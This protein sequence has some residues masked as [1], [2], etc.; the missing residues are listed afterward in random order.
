MNFRLN[1][2]STLS[3]MS[4]YDKIDDTIDEY[5]IIAIHPNDMHWFRL[6]E[7]F[8]W[9]IPDDDDDPTFNMLIMAWKLQKL[10]KIFGIDS[11]ILQLGDKTVINFA[12]IMDGHLYW[13]TDWKGRN[14]RIWSQSNCDKEHMSAFL[15]KLWDG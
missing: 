6:S 5:G 7:V 11:D 1:L 3:I 14:I 12:F 13:L 10:N 2:N 15:E 8:E 9:D 4:I